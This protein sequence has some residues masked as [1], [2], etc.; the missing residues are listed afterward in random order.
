M[1]DSTPLAALVDVSTR[2]AATR[3]RTEKRRHLADMLRSAR[4]DELGLVVAFLMGVVPHGPLGVGYAALSA[5]DVPAAADPLLSLAEIDAAF[6][7][8]AG[9]SGPGSQD[10][11]RRILE[12][13]YSSTDT[14]GQ[15]F[16]G[17][18]IGGE[19]RHGA[20]AGLMA[21]AVAEAF[22]LD[23]AAVRRA[24]MFAG[25]LVPVAVAAAAGGEDALGGFGLE[26]FT[27][28][29]PMLAQSAPSVTEAIERTG[30]AAVEWKFDGARLQI[31]RDGDTVALYTR[32]LRDITA[33]LPGIVDRIRALP[34]GT[35]ILDAE[36][37]AFGSSGRPEPFQETM[38]RF[39]TQEATDKGLDLFVF[40]ALHLDGEDL[41]DLPDA[42]RRTRLEEVVPA[43]LLVPR[44]ATH[45]PA[46]GESFFEDAIATG[47]EGVMVK[48]LAATYE[49]GRRGAG[50]IKVKPVHTLDLVVLAVEWGSGR[51]SGW[52][53]NIHLGARDPAAGTFV[54]LGKTFKGMTDEMLQW[55][56]DRFLELEER[57]TARTVWVR[58][59]QV[60][61]IAF[62]GI[63]ASTR[64][65][66]GMALRF[67][68]V[69][70]YRDDKTAEEADTIATVRQF[71]ER[72]RSG[73][74]AQGDE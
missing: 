40:D 52:L 3:K 20:Q 28:V 2:V 44:L 30:P 16:L 70:Q 42:E 37:M 17:G 67:A 74:T 13:L 36:V 43:D 31:H 49:A 65:P 12:G 11:R 29:Q 57:R 53:S 33:Q 35:M 72:S 23:A 61:E 39:G 55:Q 24:A 46:A 62:D 22:G 71:F 21:D 27:P 45:D 10:R 8:L 18:L 14:Q 66:G 15:R 26:L 68:R 50:W 6:D 48:S 54:M 1:S 5:L 38:G 63:Q 19:L 56:T 64:Y 34:A 9:T 7:D 51:R 4:P 25:D 60:V 69:K 73:S 59:E 32:N 58:P 47:H 41:V